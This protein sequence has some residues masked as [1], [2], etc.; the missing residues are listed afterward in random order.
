[1]RRRINAKSRSGCEWNFED[2]EEGSERAFLAAISTAG[3][4]TSRWT[5]CGLITP[6][7]VCRLR[8][9]VLRGSPPTRATLVACD[10][11]SVPPAVVE[12]APRLAEAKD[13]YSASNYHDQRHP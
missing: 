13:Q 6:L 10:L 1:M 7:P 8:V 9:I 5:G 11:V 2:D 4:G 12:E 3:A